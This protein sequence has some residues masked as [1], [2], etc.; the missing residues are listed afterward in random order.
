MLKKRLFEVLLESKQARTR[1]QVEMLVTL[2][3]VLVNGTP[4]KSPN[5]TVGVGDSIVIEGDDYVSRG[6]YKLDSVAAKFGLDFKGKVVLDVGSSTGGF[7]D[8]ALQHGAKMVI[9]VEAGVNQ[10]HPRLR[11]NPRL[12]LHEKTDIRG[13]RK[14]SVLPDI[15]VIDLSFISLREVL[16]EVGRLCTPSTYLIAMVKPQFEA[17]NHNLKHKG[18]IK[19]EKIRRDILKSF[20][21]WVQNLFIIRDK[22]DSEVTGSKGNRERFYVLRKLKKLPRQG[23]AL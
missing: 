19:N 2:G 18:V 6:G 20:E 21:D 4:A 8:Y 17:T 12:E 13:V 11:G 1:S 15:A 9:A 5:S 7:T 3:K 16:Q 22:A 23:A 10:L 14:L